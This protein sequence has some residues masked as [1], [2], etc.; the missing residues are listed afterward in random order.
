MKPTD[1]DLGNDADVEKGEEFQALTPETPSPPGPSARFAPPLVLRLFTHVLSVVLLA[2][3]AFYA[4]QQ[5]S[6]SRGSFCND[7]EIALPYK[8]QTIPFSTL[9][10]L[11]VVGPLVL[12][13]LLEALL[14][15]IRSA[16]VAGDEKKEPTSKIVGLC[17]IPHGLIEVYRHVGAFLF[18]CVACWL[19]TEVLKE[20]VGSLRPHFLSVCKPDWSQISCKENELYTYVS[21]FFCTGDAHR[22]REGRRSFPSGHSSMAMCGVLF[23]MLYLQG[24][25]KWQQHKTAP[26]LQQQQRRAFLSKVYWMIEAATPC[27]QVLLFL[28]ALYI[29]ATR[30]LD[31]YHHVRDVVGG[32][33][34]GAF[35]AL[36]AAFFVVDLRA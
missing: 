12:I 36:H 4:L 5:Y 35:V 34:L 10:Y 21:D 14:S 11:C 7:T 3:L 31:H 2:G 32:G 23:T 33:V 16:N 8:E 25:F 9:V 1:Q 30:V 13:L 6:S 15:A 29:P 28:M 24:R 18:S 26:R 17:E 27:L 20:V 22:I 19:L